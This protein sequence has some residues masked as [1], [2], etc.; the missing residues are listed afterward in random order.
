MKNKITL[1]AFLMIHAHLC[2]SCSTI[3]KTVGLEIIQMQPTIA[4]GTFFSDVLANQLANDPELSS[5][6]MIQQNGGL[7]SGVLLQPNWVLTAAHA[8]S[9]GGGRH[10]LAGTTFLIEG[11][12]YAADYAEVNPTWKGNSGEGNDLA[13]IHLSSSITSVKP[14]SFQLQPENMSGALITFAGYGL[15]GNGQSG[16]QSGTGGILRAGTNLL[17]LNGSVLGMDSSVYLADFDSGLL[18]DNVLGSANPSEFESIL[19]PGDSGGGAFMLYQ[20]QFILVGINSF[21]AS[22]TGSANGTY[23]NIAGF[24]AIEPHLAWIQSITHAPEPASL[25]LGVVCA[26]VGWWAIENHSGKSQNRPPELT[27]KTKRAR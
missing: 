26:L 20:G 3:T 7:A 1:I 17:D 24:Q 10:N 22:T 21:L 2:V 27:V 12:S 15:G 9:S 6:G 4:R 16:Y 23:G 5:V 11:V 8:I 18:S 13:L 19:T 25:V 14:A